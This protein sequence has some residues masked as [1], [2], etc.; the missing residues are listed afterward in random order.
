VTGPE[1]YREAE[2]LLKAANPG[3]GE[4]VTG[5]LLIAQAH[6]LLAVAAA[7]ALNQADAGMW[8]AD[9]AAWRDVAGVRDGAA[10]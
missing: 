4:P 9:W 5:G 1:H 6:A 3:W 2:A 10:T 8:T 7:T